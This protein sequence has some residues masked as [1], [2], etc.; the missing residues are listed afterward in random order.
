MCVKNFFELI[1]IVMI[2]FFNFHTIQTYKC[3]NIPKIRTGPS[4]PI[5]LMPP[6]LQGS[7]SHG[8]SGKSATVSPL[9]NGIVTSCPAS[10]K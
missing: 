1:R 5:S 6:F 3:A 9:L 8:I 7:V 4:D 2:Y 10:K